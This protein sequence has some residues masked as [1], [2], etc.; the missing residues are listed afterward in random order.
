MTA[1]SIG[2]PFDRPANK[3]G[4]L[5]MGT[6]PKNEKSVI[7]SPND[8]RKAVISNSWLCVISPRAVGTFRKEIATSASGD[9]DSRGPSHSNR[10]TRTGSAISH[11]RCPTISKPL[12]IHSNTP[13]GREASL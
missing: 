10:S 12:E 7:L 11:N 1:I 13:G 5:S 9:A 3:L 8:A 2:G 6:S 4:T